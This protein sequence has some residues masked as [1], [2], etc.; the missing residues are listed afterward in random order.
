MNMSSAL[1]NTEVN[2]TIPNET[3]VRVLITAILII[4]C[5]FLLKK[6]LG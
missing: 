5:Y 4:L 6:I 3:L 1:I 2:I